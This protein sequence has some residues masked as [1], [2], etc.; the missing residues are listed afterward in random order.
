M[1]SFSLTFGTA[2]DLAS[3]LVGGMLPVYLVPLGVALGVFILGALIKAMSGIKR[4]HYT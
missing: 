1:L 3:D 2:L 4:I